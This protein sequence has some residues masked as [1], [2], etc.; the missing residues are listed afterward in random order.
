MKLLKLPIVIIAVLI[1]VSIFSIKIMKQAGAVDANKNPVSTKEEVKKE[2][3]TQQKN[4]IKVTF[5]ELGSVKC[6]PCK[7]MQPIMDDIKK[8][9]QGQVEVVFYDVW[10]AAGRPYGEKYQIRAI[11]TQVFLDKDGKEY[12]RHVGFFPKE[13]LVKILKQQGVK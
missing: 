4:T 8:E 1:I 5:I 10:T 9:Y 7:M 6:V 11:P 12:S 3:L 2:P 13:E